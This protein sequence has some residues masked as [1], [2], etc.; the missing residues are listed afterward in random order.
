MRMLQFSRFIAMTID[1]RGYQRG[2]PPR[3]TKLSTV[4]RFKANGKAALVHQAKTLGLPQKELETSFL[5]ED[6]DADEEKV[7]SMN[8]SMLSINQRVSFDRTISHPSGSP[9]WH[10]EIEKGCEVEKALPKFGQAVRVLRRE[11]TG[12]P[13]VLPL[14]LGHVV[15][16]ACGSSNPDRIQ[17][18]PVHGIPWIFPGNLPGH[19]DVNTILGM[20]L[21]FQQSD[22]L[23]SGMGCMMSS[24]SLTVNG[25]LHFYF[26]SLAIDSE[27]HCGTLRVGGCGLPMAW[28]TVQGNLID[29]TYHYWPCLRGGVFNSEL[30]NVKKE[31]FYYEEDPAASTVPLMTELGSRTCVT[32]PSL[33][34]AYANPEN[35]QK[36]LFFRSEYPR[37]FPNLQL[38][39]CGIGFIS[40]DEG[41]RLK[42]RLG[43]LDCHKEREKMTLQCWTCGAKAKNLKQ[44]IG[45]K[46]AKYCKTKCQEADWPIHKLLHKD[47]K[48]NIAFQK[49][50]MEK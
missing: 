5:P 9:Q 24:D 44:C 38:Y 47:V 26:K 27:L 22:P 49:Q 45:C 23:N 50:K 31:K 17:P 20:S 46:V 21:F 18:A 1:A 15:E 30:L 12:L 33:F 34:K 29:N 42:S 14:E 36:F 6:F 2:L 40:E 16:M 4:D 39:I 41:I 7:A 35:I 11:V 32:N 13:T 37:V 48:E 10:R 43:Y 19:Q 8:A 28:L 25:M 3:D